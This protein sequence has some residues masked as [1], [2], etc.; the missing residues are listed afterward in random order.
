MIPF[1]AFALEQLPGPPA[2]LLE[3]GCGQGALTT[4]LSVAGYAILGIDPAAP[5]SEFFR[6]LT[7]DDL[8]EPGPY[9]GVLAA[10][11]LHHIRDLD[12]ALDKVVALLGPEGVFVVEEFGWDQLDDATFDWLHGQRR[13][14]AAAGRGQAPDSV[15]ALR[16]EWEGERLGLH[17]EETLLEALATRFEEQA[18][19]RTPYLHRL[20]GGVATEV[21]EQAL[22][23][24]GAIKALGFHWA[25]R[26]RAGAT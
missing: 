1:E 12:A 20:L 25:G 11:S 21:L 26:P 16:S 18:Y 24:G 8:D 15:E 19:V 14:L 5:Q 4:A 3:I 13:A 17:G 10:S 7:F 22:I 9:D 6:R 2:R 23:D